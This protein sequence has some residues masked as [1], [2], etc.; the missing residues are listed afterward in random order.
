MR[1]LENQLSVDSQHV[2]LQRAAYDFATAAHLEAELGPL[3]QGDGTVEFS[4]V[5]Y[6]DS[7]SLAVL[8]RALK[9]MRE[10]D[11]NSSLHLTNVKPRLR[12]IMEITGLTALF[13]LR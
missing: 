13:V 11:P 2:V 1:E 4:N 12:R 7:S 9:R 8:I 5:E 3:I 10:A 6:I